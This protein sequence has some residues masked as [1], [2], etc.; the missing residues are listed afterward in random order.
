MRETPFIE[1]LRL[2]QCNGKAE[3]LHKIVAWCPGWGRYCRVRE[4][5]RSDYAMEMAGRRLYFDFTIDYVPAAHGDPAFRRIADFKIELERYNDLRQRRWAARWE[6]EQ[7][8]SEP[9]ARCGL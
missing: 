8:Q 9:P 6:A 3:A 2:G 1:T 7:N 5:T 4:I